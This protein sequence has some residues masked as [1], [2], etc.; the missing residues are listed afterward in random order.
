M[1]SKKQ[2]AIEKA[3][4]YCGKSFTAPKY[5]S[6]CDDCRALDDAKDELRFSNACMNYR[7]NNFGKNP[8]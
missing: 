5:R 3:C 6:M 1:K 4:N 8:I 2:E 7:S